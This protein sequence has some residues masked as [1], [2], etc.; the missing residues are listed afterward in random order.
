MLSATTTREDPEIYSFVSILGF[1]S[2]SKLILTYPFDAT[3]AN[4]SRQEVIHF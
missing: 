3:N 4:I 2:L 1:F